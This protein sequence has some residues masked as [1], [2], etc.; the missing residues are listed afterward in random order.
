MILGACD[1]RAR[2]VIARCRPLG[3]EPSSPII[4]RTSPRTFTPWA[5][6]RPKNSSSGSFGED[7]LQAS[8]PIRSARSSNVGRQDGGSTEAPA[9]TNKASRP[10]W[11]ASSSSPGRSS[12]LNTMSQCWADSPRLFHYP[13]APHRLSPRSMGIAPGQIYRPTLPR[14]LIFFARICSRP[15]VSN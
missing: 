14:N 15:A 6:R 11:W 1:D 2:A 12:A 10:C 7:S 8:T 5:L 3:D 4:R 13:M 9:P